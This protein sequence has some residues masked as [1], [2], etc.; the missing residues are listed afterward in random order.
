MECSRLQSIW[1]PK[2]WM[3]AQSPLFK[4]FSGRPGSTWM[5]ISGPLS[6]FG[7]LTEYLNIY[8]KGLNVKQT[9]FAIHKY[10]SHPKIG[11]YSQV[12]TC[13]IT[14]SRYSSHIARQLWQLAQ[15]PLCDVGIVRANWRTCQ[16]QIPLSPLEIQISD[17][18]FGKSSNFKKAIR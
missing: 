9:E 2:F 11:A 17:D 4:H 7:R 3:P 16:I 14:A 13:Q 15:P 5:H 6:G 10:C 1:F 12:L 8:S 18:P